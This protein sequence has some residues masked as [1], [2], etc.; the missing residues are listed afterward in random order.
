LIPV[1]SILS[2]L[3][4]SSCKQE[5]KTDIFVKRY[6]L[7]NADT[8]NIVSCISCGSCVIDFFESN[9]INSKNILVFDENCG[10]DFIASLRKY[11]H[12]NISQDSLDYYFDNFGDIMTVVK[13]NN[14]YVRLSDLTKNN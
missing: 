11:K 13:K 6:N 8:I 7:L 12:N 5:S 4:L 10:S 9:L 14:S 2:I 1:I 3:S